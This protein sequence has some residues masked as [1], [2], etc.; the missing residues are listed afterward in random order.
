[1]QNLK[2]RIRWFLLVYLAIGFATALWTNVTGDLTVFA[3]TGSVKDNA[4][5]WFWW[6][7]VP[8]LIW[9]YF[10]F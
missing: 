2:H 8:I 5:L 1:M 6:F 9:P 7:I 4:I 10:L 3:W